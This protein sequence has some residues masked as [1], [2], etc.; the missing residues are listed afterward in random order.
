MAEELIEYR[1]KPVTRYIVTR[2]KQGA[3]GTG[4]VGSVG[5]GEFDDEQTAYEVGYALA[6]ADHDRMGW[7]V[8]DPRIQYPRNPGAEVAPSVPSFGAQG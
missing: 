7:P 1:V 3:S 6:K 2:F 8:G 5:R 4:V